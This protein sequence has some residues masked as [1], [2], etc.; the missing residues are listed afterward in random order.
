MRRAQTKKEIMLTYETLSTEKYWVQSAQ[1]E[2][3]SYRR[4]KNKDAIRSL[5]HFLF[6]V[7]MIIFVVIAAQTMPTW[8][9]AVTDY[10]AYD[11]QRINSF[12][13]SQ[14]IGT[15]S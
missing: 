15:G 11:L 5:F 4:Q 10:V 2:L 6:A 8:L 1:V 7:G 13:Q 14:G 3:A 12:M 9:P